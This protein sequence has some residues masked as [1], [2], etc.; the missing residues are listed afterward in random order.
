MPIKIGKKVYRSHKDAERS[1]RRARPDIKDP[2]AY[3]ATIERTV[4]KRRADKKKKG[5]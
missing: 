2:A 4:E 3:V 5:R 1:V